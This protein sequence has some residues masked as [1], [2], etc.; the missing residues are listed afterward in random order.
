MPLWHGQLAVTGRPQSG[1][2]RNIKQ[3]LDQEVRGKWLTKK[4]D[5]A[6]FLSPPFVGF[7]LTISSHEYD[8]RCE[9][10][11]SEALRKFNAATL[12]QPNIDNETDRFSRDRSIKEL[13]RRCI[14]LRV[15]SERRQQTACGA[16]DAQVIVDYR[17]DLRLCRHG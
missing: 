11:F 9:T 10:R 7:V 1:V 5:A 4:S 8:G 2:A 6:Q 12:A 14:E 16:K 17:N 13:L 15:V 3:R